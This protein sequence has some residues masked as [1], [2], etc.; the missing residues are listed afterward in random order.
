MPKVTFLPA[1]RTVEFE[2]GTLPFPD[3]GQPGSVLAIALHFGIE[4][5]HVCGGNC[6]CTTCHV[7]IKEGVENT[8]PMLE[9]EGDLI[10]GVPGVTSTSRLGCQAVVKGDI[11]VEI[12]AV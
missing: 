12:P 5:E 9:D 10:D 3:H 8:S 6:S 1:G 11:V 4:M 2:A 7:V